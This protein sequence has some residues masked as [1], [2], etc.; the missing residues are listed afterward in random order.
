MAFSGLAGWVYF[1]GFRSPR[2]ELLD[3]LAQSRPAEARLGGAGFA[4]YEPEVGPVLFSKEARKAAQRIE[5]AARKRSPPS[6]ALGDLALVWLLS[7]RPDKAVTT[8]QQAVASSPRDTL[9]LSDLAAVYLARAGNGVHP[10]DLVRALSAADRARHSDPGSRE[11]LFNR[12]LALEK[13]GL[14]EARRAWADVAAREK[15]PGWRGEAE[16]RLH[17]LNRPSGAE[18]WDT[19]RERLERAAARGETAIV[20]V[21]VARFPQPARIHAEEVLLA[22]WA[23]E[24]SRGRRDKAA[25]YLTTTRAVGAALLRRGGD[26]MVHDTV[27]AIDEAMADPESGR[28]RH[29]VDGHRLFGPGLRNYRGNDYRKA[30]PELAQAEQELRFGRSPFARWALVYLA[31]CEYFNDGFERTQRRLE[32]L[33]KDLP[34]R[35][36]PVLVAQTAWILGS[37]ELLR[38]R[39][40]EALA[41]FQEGREIFSRLGE[42]DRLSGIRHQMALTLVLLGRSEEAWAHLFEGLRVLAQ[43]QTPRTV[44]GLLDEAGTVC[45]DAGYPD[46]ALYFQNELLSHAVRRGDPGVIAAAELLRT[47]TMSRLGRTAEAEAETAAALRHAEG[48]RE[49]KPRRRMQAEI[50][51]ARAEVR[52]RSSPLAADRDLTLAIGDLE[53][54]GYHL[55][56]PV[57]YFLRARARLIAQQFELAGQDFQ[58]GLR[59]IERARDS[60]RERRLRIAFQDQAAAFFDEVLAF[61]AD[62][63]DGSQAFVISERGRARQLL[64]SLAVASISGGADRRV[65]EPLLTAREVRRALPPGTAV[66]KYAVLRGRLLIWAFGPGGVDFRRLPV[67]RAA[68]ARSIHR[69]RAALR[70]GEDGRTIRELRDLH[71]QLIGPVTSALAGARE[72]VFVPDR[73]IHLLPFAALIDPGSGRYLVEDHAIAVAPSANVYVRCLERSRKGGGQPPETALVVGA[74]TFDFLQ[75]P[76]PRLPQAGK[77]AMLVAASY[78]RTRLLIGPEASR[79]R[80]FAELARKPEVIHFAGH[81][82]PNLAF[83]ELSLLLLAPEPGKKASGVVY[84]Y[85]VQG[86]RLDR[87]RLAV[88]SACDTAA[89]GEP[90]SEGAVGLA[91]PFLAAGV[92]SVLA[93]LAPVEDEHGREV[94]TRFHLQLRAGDSPAEALRAAQLSRLAVGGKAAQP[95]YWAMFEIIGGAPIQP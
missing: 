76:L 47:K 59:E 32:D 71:Q 85:E 49:K 61:L 30:A 73:E 29:L 83:P 18:V 25:A 48:I 66:I 39:P 8:L 4:P 79:S 20:E 65:D 74:T 34:R 5:A 7:G 60:V 91:R 17:R 72:V 22:R 58:A 31:S 2:E 55:Q 95:V 94:L 40:G 42:I 69:A 86:V 56:L 37:I 19:E 43:L 87:T 13:L 93:S 88:L 10:L 6:R 77:E 63:D 52:L 80:F 84:S 15:E 50:L 35:R 75:F 41:R 24:E 12:A 1:C 44:A 57:A 62:R 67:T 70:A 27:A 38:A 53:A 54:S 21:I 33:R 64:E 89:F 28:L 92:P 90:D 36:Y 82:V 51:I 16:A 9:L 45:L 11:A 26:A 46:V 14:P 23:E 78:P 81:A 3:L 68:L